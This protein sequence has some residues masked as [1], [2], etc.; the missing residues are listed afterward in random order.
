MGAVRIVWLINTKKDT[1]VFPIVNTTLC[2]ADYKLEQFE[3]LNL[4][5]DPYLGPDP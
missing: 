2:I 5:S 1:K 4:E 3:Y